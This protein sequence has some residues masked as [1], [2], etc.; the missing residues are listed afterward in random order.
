MWLPAALH[1]CLH[2]SNI[3]RPDRPV[4]AHCVGSFGVCLGRPKGSN[5]RDN[6]TLFWRFPAASTCQR[7]SM[8]LKPKGNTS[9]SLHW[10]AAEAG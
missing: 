3:P 9:L 5:K 2:M 8:L 7:Q 10:P 4:S 1:T 6:K